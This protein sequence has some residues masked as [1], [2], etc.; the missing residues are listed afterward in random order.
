MPDL[1]LPVSANVRASLYM[2]LSMM[3]FTINDLFIK[4]LGDELA[5]GQ[6]MA[7]RGTMLFVIIALLIWQQNLFPRIRE[8][9]SRLIFFRSTMEVCATLSFLTTLQ[10][11]PFATIAAIL[12]S[13]PL[14][15]AVGAAI[16]L[17]EPVGWRRW[18]AIIVGFV[19]VIIIIRPGMGNFEAMSLLVLLSV[20]FAAARDL[21]T[22]R[23]PPSLP[24]LLV[25]A[26]TTVTIAIAGVALT[27]VKG[28]WQS[29]TSQQL[30]V[31]AMAACFLFFGYQFIVMAM[32]TGEVAYVV[33]FRYT[34]L[35]WAIVLGYL[36]FNEVPDVL[37]LVGS[38][39][40]IATG[41]FTLYREIINGRRAVTSTAVNAS[42]NVWHEKNTAT[43]NSKKQRPL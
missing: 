32:R 18:I 28:E 39:I 2:M 3:G 23:L 22:R 42:G 8:L 12:Q 27:T 36:I 31:L 9:F 17:G 37:T 16:F 43:T 35:I 29:V 13:L 11:L 34:S 21:F 20:F 4:S 33:P 1:S 38:A 40:V 10:L 15:V 24:S 14:A 30:L 41:L 26:A 19:G 6:I 7:I 25:S 5:V